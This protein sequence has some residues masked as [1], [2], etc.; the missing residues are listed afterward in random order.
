MRIFFLLPF[1]GCSFSLVS[2]F[3]FVTVQF[4]PSGY[5][6][7]GTR[8]T[9][10]TH[11]HARFARLESSPVK[12]GS[13]QGLS[14]ALG[15]LY[16][17]RPGLTVSLCGTSEP[18]ATKEDQLRPVSG[19]DQRAEGHLCPSP[20][21]LECPVEGQRPHFELFLGIPTVAISG[22]STLRKKRNKRSCFPLLSI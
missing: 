15:A 5:Q 3:S 19:K 10:S 11:T 8:Q 12:Q 4:H 2:S 18:H 7:E 17:P 1:F 14:Q 9:P 16:R 13:P 6:C 20:L 21:S 22:I